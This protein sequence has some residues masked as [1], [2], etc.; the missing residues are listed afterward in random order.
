VA[1]LDDYLIQR[2]LPEHGDHAAFEAMT[3][4]GRRLVIKRYSP[5]HQGGLDRWITSIQHGLS[6]PNVLVCVD[7]GVHEGWLPWAAFEWLDAGP[8]AGPRP[9]ARAVVAAVLGALAAAHARKVLHLD[10][11]AG[12]VLVGDGV[13]KLAGLGYG[14]W[15]AWAWTQRNNSTTAGRTRLA[16]F[17]HF[18]PEQAR[19][20]AATAETDVWMI[21]ALALRLTAGISPHPAEQSVIQQ[22]L[23][24]ANGVDPAVVDAAPVEWRG[25]IRR[26]LATAPADRFVDAGAALAALPG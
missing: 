2:E 26:C 22:L 11:R 8:V 13:V 21:G 15:Q 5:L 9:D 18:S 7:A 25:W 23:T 24:I 12:Y 19:G 1:R 10:V 20:T 3:P 16:P 14:A 4:S 17:D 6:H